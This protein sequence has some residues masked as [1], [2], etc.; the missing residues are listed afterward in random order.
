MTPER[1]RPVDTGLGEPA[2]GALVPPGIPPEVPSPRPEVLARVLDGLRDLP[3]RRAAA[4][5]ESAAAAA[6]A[7]GDENLDAEAV[8]PLLPLPRRR[9]TPSM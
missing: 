9:W 2:V 7:D 1:A 5:A 6:P 3:A 8:P 4:A